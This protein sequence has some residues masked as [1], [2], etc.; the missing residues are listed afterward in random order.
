[1]RGTVVILAITIVVVAVIVVKGADLEPAVA[2][3]R[4]EVYRTLW[5][6]GVGIVAVAAAAL[7]V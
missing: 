7:P 1:M 5:I 6:Q 2:V 3:L 4:A